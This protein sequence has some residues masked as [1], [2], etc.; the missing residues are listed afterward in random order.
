MMR[1]LLVQGMLAGLVAGILG[2]CFAWTIGEGPVAAAIAF[3]AHVDATAHADEYAGHGD[4]DEDEIVSRPVQSTAGLGTG[5][6]IYGVAIGG[7][8]ALVFAAA[9]GRVAPFAARGTA[10]LIG[11]LG[12]TA[13]YLVPFIKYPA[14]PPAVG[15]PDTI[16][17]RTGV[18]LAMMV[19]SIVAMV[20]A[21]L[22]QKRLLPA[23]GGWNATLLA[24]A[25]Y[26]VVISICYLVLPAINEIPQQDLPGVVRAVGG[27]E[28]TF[29]PAVIWSFRVASL[30]LQV[31]IWATVALV[32]G[33]LAQRQVSP[34]R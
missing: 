30:G 25:A 26:L 28:I 17:L 4:H 5:T 18:Y 23:Y 16:Q 11:L 34:S 32:F 8:F 13:C 3:E 22:L 1:A 31:V 20:L 6:L 19:V 21:V 10:A 7:I 9:Y 33:A 27:A 14:T 24:G 29:P 2:F 15:D 12:F